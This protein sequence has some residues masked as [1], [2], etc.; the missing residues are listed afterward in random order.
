MRSETVMSVTTTLEQIAGVDA[1]TLAAMVGPDRHRPGRAR[2]R[3]I[4][5]QV[6]IWAIV[7]HIGAI[8]GT[9]EPD[10]IDPDTIAAVA[11]ERDIPETAVAA[12][13]HYYVHNRGPIDALLEENAAPLGE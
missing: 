4:A 1:A 8:A 5:E 6:P 7:G 10:E 2:Y 12:A 11:R 3:L 9:T 13:L